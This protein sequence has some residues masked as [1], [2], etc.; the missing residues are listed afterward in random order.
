M[1]N[2]EHNEDYDDVSYLNF[3]DDSVTPV[4]AD[5]I[6]QATGNDPTLKKVFRY[7]SL[8]WPRKISCA[9]IVPYFRCKADLQIDHGILFRGHRVVIPTIFRDQLLRE[10][11]TGHLGIVKT[12]SIARGKMWWPNID[13]DIERWIGSCAACVAVRAAP[14]RAAPAPW[15]RPPSAWY[16]VH[17]D[18]MSIHQKVYL[19]V[20]DAYSKWLECLLMD[21]GTTTRALICKLK[22][23]FSRFGVPNVIV[24]DNDIKINSAEFNSFCAMNGIRY[25]TSPVYHAASNGQAENSVKTCKKMIKCIDKTDKSKVEDKLMGL[26]FEYRNTP[27]CSTGQTPASLMMGRNLRSRL[28]LVI[29]DVNKTKDNIDKCVIDNCRKFNIGDQ[30]WVKWFTEK[31]E[32]WVLGTIQNKIGNRMF[33]IYVHT[34][35]TVCRRHVDQMLMYTGG[36]FD[37]INETEDAGADEDS[38]SPP[39]EP[40]PAP[41]GSAPPAACV[42]PPPSSLRADSPLQADVQPRDVVSD[43][44]DTGLSGEEEEVEER[45][46]SRAP[47][48]PAPLPRLGRVLRLP[49]TGSYN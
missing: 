16:R 39:L 11:H 8:G 27:H 15:P 33:L 21:K 34:K 17:I 3:L 7:M 42:N 36:E 12:K 49:G 26:L 37:V 1:N 18:Y 9:S 38:W 6:R 48:L 35:N 44:Y 19:I 22:E 47:A 10:L 2:D 25:V 24:S 23:I 41:A 31:K 32:I 29:P 46:G 30:V 28:D 4:T 40:P 5:K 13:G 43:E 20:I 14:P 45:E